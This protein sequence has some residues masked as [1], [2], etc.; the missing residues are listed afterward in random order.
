MELGDVEDEVI[1][2]A[3]AIVRLKSIEVAWLVVCEL[4]SGFVKY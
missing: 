3:V 1:A 4:Y 2:K